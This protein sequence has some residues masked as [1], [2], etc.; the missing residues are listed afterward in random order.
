MNILASPLPAT[1]EIGGASVPIRTGYRTGISVARVVESGVPPRTMVRSV[2]G[3]YFP[4]GAPAPVEEALDA[5]LLFHRCGRP[6][7]KRKVRPK[8]LLDWD[9]DAGTVLADFRREYGVDLADPATRMHWWVFM[10][11]FDGLTAESG[12]KTAMY[13]RGAKRPSGASRE[14]TKRF[15][16]MKQ[17]YALPA[18][19]V[20]GGDEDA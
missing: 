15:E 19:T 3:L 1:V 14:E 5:A 10:A 6:A 12:I 13:W 9:H 17:S 8:R 16:A 11:L 2:L 7:Q 18:R 4:E 20:A